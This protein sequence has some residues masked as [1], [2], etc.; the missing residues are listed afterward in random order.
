MKGIV[1]LIRPDGSCPRVMFTR[2]GSIRATGWSPDGRWL[3]GYIYAGRQFTT[4]VIGV[5]GAPLLEANAWGSWSPDGR[6]LAVAEMDRLRILEVESDTW[7]SF[8]LLTRC[9]AVAWNPRGPLHKP[10]P[11]SGHTTS[12]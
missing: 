5:D 8:E 7:Y 12:P 3:T 4:T 11:D 2:D 9:G 1:A 10:I 6:Y